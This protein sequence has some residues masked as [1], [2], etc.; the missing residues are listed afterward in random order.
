MHFRQVSNT[1]DRDQNIIGMLR[2]NDGTEKKSKKLTDI[3][4]ENIVSLTR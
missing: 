4:R 3:L 1:K 2:N